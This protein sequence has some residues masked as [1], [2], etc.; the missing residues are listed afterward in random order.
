MFFKLTLDPDYSI[1][2]ECSGSAVNDSNLKIEQK[3]SIAFFQVE[4]LEGKTG[5]KK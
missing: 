1:N 3:P 5:I 4:A 2:I